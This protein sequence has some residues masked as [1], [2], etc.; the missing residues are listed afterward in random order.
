MYSWYVYLWLTN[1]F[2]RVTE[3]FSRWSVFHHSSILVYRSWDSIFSINQT[4]RSSDAA[5]GKR[6]LSSPKHPDRLWGPPSLLFNGYWAFYPKVKRKGLEANLSPQSS[7]K[8]KDN[9]NCTSAPCMCLCGVSRKNVTFYPLSSIP[10][11]SGP[12]VCNNPDQAKYYVS[13]VVFLGFSDPDLSGHRVRQ[14]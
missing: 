10:S 7:A 4:D 11:S 8:V 14:I 3:V 1:G 6:F 5:R 12:R 2:V 9:W 13:P